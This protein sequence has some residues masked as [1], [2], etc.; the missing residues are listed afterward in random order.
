[1]FLFLSQNFPNL[2]NNLKNLSR[3]MNASE[4][5]AIAPLISITVVSLI[6]LLI[7]GLLKQSEKFSYW[8]S[9]IGI[10]VT[11]YFALDTFSLMGTV[12]NNMIT[13]GGFGSMFAILFSVAALLTIILSRDYLEREK[14]HFG[15]FYILILLATL[16][17]MLMAYAADLI[18]IF[19]GLELMS[20][21][22]Y[23]LAGFFR[24]KIL[25]NE[26]SLKYFLLG[27]FATGF[28]LYGIAL[29]YGASGTTSISI[30]SQ[31]FSVYSISPFFWIGIG[32]F[33]IGLAFK[34]GAV[35][36]HMW[37]PD[38]Y[39]GSPTTVSGFMATGAKA[40]AFAA[41]VLFFIHPQF[42]S[43]EQIK[44]VLVVIS[45]A[46]MILGN[47]IAISQSN[48]KRMLAYSSI[49]HAGYM[50]AG[51]AAGNQLGKSGIIFYLV[52]YTFMN[53]GAFGVLSLL[54]KDEE[55]N[56][57][58]DDY[59]GL[60]FK[61]PFLAALMSIFMFSLAGIPPFAGFFGKYYV[62]VAAINAN[63][64]WLAILG[65]LM[66]VVSVYYYLRLTVL[67]YFRDGEIQ[68]EGL[69]SKA[70]LAVLTVAALVIIEL[71]LY[72][73]TILNIINNLH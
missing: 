72:P 62:F 71:G 31:N 13:V 40:A 57:S 50:L 60:G 21:C 4:I 5:F 2:S 12:F 38:V 55:K 61:K 66:S 29:L 11:I 3:K 49:A 16:G 27:A 6:V 23:V 1:M 70:S 7:E 64:T 39:Q 58:F 25:S 42:R 37:I 46:S 54:E 36:F 51:L 63:L 33:I 24:K 17:M 43:Q 59:A 73:S 41:F 44:T 69:I 20:I 35:P 30:L 9:I 22:L 56:L 18:V 45:A 10:I 8:V 65:V 67:M 15:E 53:I 32:F 68:T 34:V 52:T 19:L 48:I 26:A 14:A 28:L 47:V